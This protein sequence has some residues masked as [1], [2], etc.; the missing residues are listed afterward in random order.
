MRPVMLEAKLLLLMLLLLLLL[1]W[2]LYGD[3]LWALSRAVGGPGNG[4]EL[5]RSGA[6][7]RNRGHG[8]LEVWRDHFRVFLQNFDDV[9]DRWSILTFVFPTSGEQ[10][11]QVFGNGFGEA[12]LVAGFHVFDHLAVGYPV[13]G[14]AS[15]SFWKKGMEHV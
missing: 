15:E 13:V 11:A 5:Q 2:L 7:D 14:E 8:R 10:F 4:H 12:Q 9:L 3:S 6:F 1:L